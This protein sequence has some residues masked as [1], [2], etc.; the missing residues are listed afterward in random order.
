M[1]TTFN[2]DNSGGTSRNT[3]L[4]SVPRGE[5]LRENIAGYLFISPA[6]LVIAIF[7]IFPIGYAI[8][9]SLH[10]W[11]IR[12]GQFYCTPDGVFDFGS[13]FT[14]YTEIVGD[15]FGLLLFIGGFGFL[16]LA[17]WAWNKAF[18][19]PELHAPDAPQRRVI[20][21]HPTLKIVLAVAILVF[22][23]FLITQGWGRML[24]QGDDAFLNGLIVTFYFAISS[25]PIQLALG[26]ILAYVL[27]QNIKGKEIYRMIFFLP[28]ITPAVAAAV[29]FR[30]VFSARDNALANQF[31]GLFGFEPQRWVSEP[32]PFVNAM[33]GLNLEGFLAGPSMALVS[34]VMLGIWT[35]TGYNAVLFLAGLGNIP[36]DLYDAGKVDGA[37]DFQLFR[38][39]TLPLIS[40]VTF[41]LSILGFIG[42][43]QAF[44][45]IFVMRTPFAQD[46]V[47]TVSIV[48]F[49]RFYKA[50]QYGEATAMAVLLMLV[51]LA[52]TQFQRSVLEK[53]VFY[54]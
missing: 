23:L 25:V 6:L 54:G 43:F 26:L 27:F 17:W 20:R 3:F 16:L 51:I 21:L 47:D 37:N 45:T 7:G 9:M 19:A 18:N 33:F 4:P 2:P 24:V 15:W 44:N 5:R 11:R 8:Y 46:T 38:Y 53:R 30:T 29:V 32:A 39:I 31:I 28:Y 48:I 50:S 1:T 52:I 14:N 34:I 36:R 12:R 13:C 41:Y 40:P 35:Y 49:D 42:T 22:A 10:R